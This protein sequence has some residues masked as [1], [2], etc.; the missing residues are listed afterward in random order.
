MEGKNYEVQDKIRII[1]K[2]KWFIFN[3]FFFAGVIAAVASFM[4]T[5]TYQAESVL[6]IHQ[7]RGVET[8]L[9]DNR[10]NAR[11]TSKQLM[12]TYA[13]MIKS[14]GVVEAVIEKANF[15]ENNKPTYEAMK[16]RIILQTVK[17]TELLSVKVQASSPEEA[18]KLANLLTVTFIERLTSLVRSE[19]KDVRIFIGD[20]LVTA[21]QDLEKAEQAV[22]NFKRDEKVVSLPDATRSLVEW[23]TAISRLS[24][25]NRV[26]LASAQARVAN[27]NREL[28]GENAGVV[29]DNPLIQQYK[30]RLADQQIE[31]ANL[32]AR[33]NEQHPSVISARATIEETKARLDNEITKVVN[34]EAPSMNPAHQ[35]VLQNKIQA[36]AEIAATNAQQGAIA[37]ILTEGEEE[38]ARL[39]AKEQNLA[40]MTRDVSVAQEVYTML[41][42]RFEEA[43]ISEVMQSTDVQMVDTAIASPAPVKPAKGLNIVVAS[44]L[45]LLIGTGMA[46]VLSSVRRTIDTAED[47]RRYLDLP[48]IASIP[49]YGPNKRA[50][51]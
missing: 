33:Y 20:R 2:Y 16:S 43:K 3:W 5:P 44:L 46:V 48:V 9:S 45:G 47:V 11:D 6:R 35:A 4:A 1:K 26:T 40:R 38:M 29:A 36:Q 19:Q 13:D 10:Q 18:Q 12:A 17:D 24:A 15:P 39:P 37:R 8:A 28:A 14:R 34:R 32:L 27:A 21:K 50:E 30:G 42:R 31:L 22:A 25:E 41:A 23:Q 49:M 51:K 7:S